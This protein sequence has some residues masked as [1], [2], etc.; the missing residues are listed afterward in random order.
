MRRQLNAILAVAGK[1]WQLFFADKR[2]ALLCFAVPIVLASAFGLI[3]ARQT[4]ARSTT[5]LPIAI[6]VEDD[7]PFTRQIADA[8][9][10][11]ERFEEP[12]QAEARAYSR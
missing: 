7:G 5:R 3:F 10:A 4:E 8:L 11:S 12:E 2:A 1:D 9:L 6:V